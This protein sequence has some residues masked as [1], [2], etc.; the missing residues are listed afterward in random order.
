MMQDCE[1]AGKR[2][3]ARSECM[4]FDVEQW[5]PHLAGFDGDVLTNPTELR[6]WHLVH[7]HFGAQ[8][9]P[10][11][12]MPKNRYQGMPETLWHCT[13]APQAYHQLA[14]RYGVSLDSNFTTNGWQ[15]M[16]GWKRG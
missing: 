11:P 9:E 13:H 4:L 8:Y 3:F 2:L 16:P 1:D 6:I 10:W 7:T 14:S 15:N 5:Y 12:L